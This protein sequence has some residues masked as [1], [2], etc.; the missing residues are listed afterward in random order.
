MGL[1]LSEAVDKMRGAINTPIIIT[2]IRE[3]KRTF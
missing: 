2:V 3:G 1:S